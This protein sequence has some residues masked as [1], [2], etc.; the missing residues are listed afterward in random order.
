MQMTYTPAAAWQIRV[1]LIMEKNLKYSQLKSH[2]GENM[3]SVS[4]ISSLYL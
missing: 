1:I 4:G 2:S 3:V